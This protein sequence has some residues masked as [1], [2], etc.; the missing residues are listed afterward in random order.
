MPR[1]A[2]EESTMPKK[3]SPDIQV[4]HVMA[5]LEEMGVVVV[6]LHFLFGKMDPNTVLVTEGKTSPPILTIKGPIPLP[7]SSGKCWPT[8]VVWEDFAKRMG[9]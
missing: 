6:N 5:A 2:A 4:K 3:K 1:D 7:R 8:P 9:F